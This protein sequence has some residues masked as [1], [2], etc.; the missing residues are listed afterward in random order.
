MRSEKKIKLSSA[1]WGLIFIGI[2]YL[3]EYLSRYFIAKYLSIDSLGYFFTGISLAYLVMSLCLMGIPNEY[4]RRGGVKRTSLFSAYLSYTTIFFI[5]NISIFFITTSFYIKWNGFFLF[6]LILGYYRLSIVRYSIL[7]ERKSGLF[8]QE[9]LNRGGRLL[10]VIIIIIIGKEYFDLQIGYILASVFSMIIVL[11]LVHHHK[12]HSLEKYISIKEIKNLFWLSL[13]LSLGVVSQISA[14]RIE[15]IIPEIMEGVDLRSLGVYAIYLTLAQFVVLPSMILTFSLTPKISKLYSKNKHNHIRLKVKNVSL[16][17]A[18]LS[19]IIM[20]I[21]SFFHEYIVHTL[22]D[23]NFITWEDSE[24]FIFLLGYWLYA[25]STPLINYLLGI[26]AYSQYT[27]T[28]VLTALFRISII[29]LLLQSE[30][31]IQGLIYSSFLSFL[32]MFSL[33][34]IFSKSLLFPS[35]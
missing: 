9:V 24:V 10:S 30:W 1:V 28:S 5:I 16:V 6:S 7:G 8:F 3:F 33:F 22:F 18:I 2:G 15:F 12:K 4:A 27:F 21:L 20:A 11:M 26:G 35:S 23:K 34:S 29:T 31:G 13:P 32:L 14:G 17:I 25:I 19:F